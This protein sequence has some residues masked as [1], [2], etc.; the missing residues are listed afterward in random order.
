MAEEN[1]FCSPDQDSYPKWTV[2][3]AMAWKVTPNIPQLGL[4]GGRA[5]ILEYKRAWIVH[6]RLRIM[7]AAE[8]NHIPADLL[9]CV[10]FNEV[11]GDPPWF[12]RNVVLAAR[13][14]LFWTKPP[15]LTSEGAIKI[16]LRAALSA[17]GYDG[18]PLTHS[19]QDQLTRCLE[20]DIFNIGVVATFLRKM[21][22]YDYPGVDTRTLTDEQFA[23][24][25]SRYNRGTERKLSDFVQSLKDA[26]GN[27]NRA[28]TEYGR[29]MLS[30]R[31]EVRSL[32]MQ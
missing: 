19:E 22:L 32:L 5:R 7:G 25:G 14:N 26:P 13:Q 10:I 23:I 21:I 3:D 31:Q 1:K 4:D 11:G 30:H 16:Q 2:F 8:T 27:P 12:K 17:I 18:P 15:Q 20:T 28:Y 24:A 29:A 6:N 9:G